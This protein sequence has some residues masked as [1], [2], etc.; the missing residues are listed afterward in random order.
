MLYTHS[1]NPAVRGPGLV[2]RHRDRRMLQ[3]R[4][5]AVD[6]TARHARSNGLDGEVSTVVETHV[7]QLA[8]VEVLVGLAWIRHQRDVPVRQELLGESS[9]LRTTAL[10]G[11]RWLRQ[12]G[13]PD[14]QDP[15]PVI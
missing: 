8:V 9:S 5:T 2:L 6:V 12:L 11:A 4:F 15:N 13:C 14:T 10:S 1:P 7:P 3:N